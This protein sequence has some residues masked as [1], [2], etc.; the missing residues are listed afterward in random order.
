[1]V[2]ARGGKFFGA[3]V[4]FSGG[5]YLGVGSAGRLSES[6]FLGVENDCLETQHVG[7]HIMMIVIV[8]PCDTQMAR[9][10]P[11]RCGGKPQG[12]VATAPDTKDT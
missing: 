1:M 5:N 11:E 10:F 9:P 8:T 12:M 2:N 7:S 3:K 4:L 6:K